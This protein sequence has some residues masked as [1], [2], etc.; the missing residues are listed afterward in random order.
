M[1]FIALNRWIYFSELSTHILLIIIVVV[2]RLL[3][4]N[5]RV[6][7]IIRGWNKEYA[8]YSNSSLDSNTASHSGIVCRALADWSIPRRSIVFDTPLG[9][10]CR[11]TLAI[12]FRSRRI[13]SDVIVWRWRQ[14]KYFKTSFMIY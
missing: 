10:R 1:K 11:K 6:G 8:T 13:S 14:L 3:V 7:I 12:R 5:N 2:V 9:L 4:V